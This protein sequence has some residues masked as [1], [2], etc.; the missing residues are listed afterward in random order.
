MLELIS[1]TSLNLLVLVIA[2]FTFGL[3]VFAIAD[4]ALRPTNA[5]LAAG[6]LTKLIWLAILGVA[7]RGEPRGLQPVDD[8]Q[9]H[10]RRRRDRVP[11]RRA[12]GAAR[13]RARRLRS[14]VAQGPDGNP[15]ATAAGSQ[16][17]EPSPPSPVKVAFSAVGCTYSP[18]TRPPGGGIAQVASRVV[19]ATRCCAACASGRTTIRSMSTCGGRVT[20]HAM[21]SATS[22]ASQRR[23]DPGVDGV[24]RG[25]VTVEPVQREL[26]GADHARCDLADPHG[27]PDQLQPQRLAQ[28]ARRRAWR[29]R[30]HPRPRRP[31]AR[32]SS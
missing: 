27:A 18:F 2:V 19:R 17:T 20:H 5:F 9:R 13:A 14:F 4:A 30:S 16:P 24:G 12:P 25:L 22:S 1:G 26:L 28:P 15:A 10:R 8:P 29:R 11:R 31:C 23:V 3:K 7:L 6:K 32:R 21:Q